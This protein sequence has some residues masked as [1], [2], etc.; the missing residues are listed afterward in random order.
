M[1]ETTQDPEETPAKSGKFAIILW[2]IL[3]LAGAGAG[4]AAVAMNLIPLG[5]QPEGAS[6][7][8]EVKIDDYT[9]EDIAFVSIDP[10]MITLN[11]EGESHQLRFRA[12]V[13]V[14]AGATATVTKIM[15]RI[16]DVMNGYLRAL[17]LDDLRDPLA[18]TRLRAQLLR[19]IAIVTGDG[20]VRDLLIMEFVLN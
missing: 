12:E 10:I 17:T 19:R 13:E 9:A 8:A 1:T 18:L 4:Y 16:V 11:S 5:K 15:P 20:M 3:A 14:A 2:V 6:P 7:Q